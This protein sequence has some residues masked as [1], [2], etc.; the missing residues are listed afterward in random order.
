MLVK[1][2][3][4]LIGQLPVVKAMRSIDHVR[5]L[6]V[7]LSRLNSLCSMQSMIDYRW[8]GEWVQ[9]SRIDDH[10]KR[11]ASSPEHHARWIT[12]WGGTSWRLGLR[13]TFTLDTC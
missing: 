4:L 13:S 8:Q 6:R 11:L 5:T 3:I 1:V 10:Y 12:Y 9:D 2:R 7:A